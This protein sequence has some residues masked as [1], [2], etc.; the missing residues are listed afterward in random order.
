[1][2]VCGHSQ[3]KHWYM[4]CKCNARGQNSTDSAVSS[5][6]LESHLGVRNRHGPSQ[7]TTK[8]SIASISVTK[9]SLNKSGNIHSYL[10]MRAMSPETCKEVCMSQ[11]KSFHT[12]AKRTHHNPST[13]MYW[14]SYDQRHVEIWLR[15]VHDILVPSRTICRQDNT[16]HNIRSERTRLHRGFSS[17]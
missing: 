1:M 8:S 9:L 15:D 13:C 4:S 5:R 11:M 16:A 7:G 12:F 17:R 14:S 3:S 10:C 2:S 6:T